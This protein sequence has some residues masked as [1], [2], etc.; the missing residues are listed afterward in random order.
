L[1][2]RSLFLLDEEGSAMEPL[3][4]LANVLYLLSYFVRDMLRLR[5]LTVAAGSCLAAYFYFQPE[6]LLIAVWWNLTF[7][8]INLFRIALLIKRGRRP[9]LAHPQAESSESLSRIVHRCSP[10][11]RCGT[12][13]EKRATGEENAGPDPAQHHEQA[14]PETRQVEYVYRSPEES[15]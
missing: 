8:G 5:N 12:G 6:P 2:R 7:I 3:I 4:N 14:P 13:D 10:A 9:A 15:G 11:S 1:A